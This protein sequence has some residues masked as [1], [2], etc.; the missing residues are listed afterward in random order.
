MNIGYARISTRGQNESLQHQEESLTAHGCER[1]Y[2]DIASGNKSTR[3]GLEQVIE[4]ARKGDAIVVIRL[5]RLGRSTID[6]LKTVK[7]LDERGI[8]IEALE[9]PSS[10][11]LPQPGDSSSPPLPPWLS[12]NVTYS[13]SA[14]TK[15]SPPPERKEES[16]ADPPNSQLTNVRQH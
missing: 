6:T 16:E 1:I 11:P 12:E 10:I 4:F 14:P 9:T 2:T 15:D 5:D 7:E 8:R 3:L 13:S